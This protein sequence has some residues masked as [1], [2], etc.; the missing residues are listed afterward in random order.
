MTFINT[1]QQHLFAY[2]AMFANKP[3]ILSTYA[4]I[5]GNDMDNHSK[6][7]TAE[8]RRLSAIVLVGRLAED[9]HVRLYSSIIVQAPRS[10]PMNVTWKLGLASSQPVCVLG[11]LSRLLYV[12]LVW[13]ALDGLYISLLDQHSSSHYHPDRDTA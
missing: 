3:P 1:L 10:L 11:P 7:R 12:Y 5:K 4:V 6:R 2:A 13:C 9:D 8:I